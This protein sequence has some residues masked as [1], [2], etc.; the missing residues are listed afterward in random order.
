M[1]PTLSLELISIIKYVIFLYPL[2]NLPV[3]RQQIGQGI[4]GNTCLL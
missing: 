1:T 4:T 3:L 2:S